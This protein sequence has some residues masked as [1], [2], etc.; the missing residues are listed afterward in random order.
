MV[1]QYT[2]GMRW[3]GLSK[4]GKRI[5]LLLIALVLI[6]MAF[7][8]LND[9]HRIIAYEPAAVATLKSGIFVSQVQ[10]QANWTTTSPILDQDGN[11]IGEYGLL[12][13]I[14][15]RRG[16]GGK[17]TGEIR[18]L[19]G[20]L[21]ENDVA[22]KYRFAIFLPDGKG[23]AIPEPAEKGPRKLLGKDAAKEQ[24]RH[25]VAY[26]WPDEPDISKRMFAIT[27]TGQLLCAPWEGKP[28][29]W[30]AVF[31]GKGWDSEPVWKPY[32]K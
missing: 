27:E 4:V 10:F 13:E 14:S 16:V 7:F 12:S 32:P 9:G 3:G 8:P 6:A 15:G 1:R 5:L 20:P 28:P 26:A 18:F 23:G 11:G 17:G 29:E 19:S 21:A 31:G 24:E 2:S 30:N 22:N 25:F